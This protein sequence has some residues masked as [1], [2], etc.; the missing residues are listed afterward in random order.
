MTESQEG[1]RKPVL[2]VENNFD[3]SLGG[4]SADSDKIRIQFPKGSNFGGRQFPPFVG[5]PTSR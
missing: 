5:R 4:M 1:Q 2:S 3:A